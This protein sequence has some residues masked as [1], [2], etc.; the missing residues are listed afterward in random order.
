MLLVLEVWIVAEGVILTA[1]IAKKWGRSSRFTKLI[2]VVTWAGF[3]TVE[4]VFGFVQ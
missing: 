4:A 2:G 3:L 1:L